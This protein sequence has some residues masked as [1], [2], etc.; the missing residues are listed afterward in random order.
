MRFRECRL[1][2]DGSSG[3]RSMCCGRGHVTLLMNVTRR[4]DCK[5]YWC[6]YVRCRTC[7]LTV[8]THRCR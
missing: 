5:Y 4:C 2:D 8:E 7:Q 6:C 3:C 1:G